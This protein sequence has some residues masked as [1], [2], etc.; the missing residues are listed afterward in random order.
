MPCG[1]ASASVRLSVARSNGLCGAIQGAKSAAA[2]H[3]ASTSADTIATGE[4]RKPYERSASHQRA[5]RLVGTVAPPA[6][7]IASIRAWSIHHGPLELV[8]IIGKLHR[9]DVFLHPPGECLLMQR[10]RP[11]FLAV[12]LEQLRDH[13]IAFGLVE[14]TRDCL[15]QLVDPF[16]AVAAE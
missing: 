8:D 13:R 7:V 9:F 6:V 2:R 15:A 1:G 11:K 3:M 16:V 14:L 10:Q 5:R 12:D 4:W